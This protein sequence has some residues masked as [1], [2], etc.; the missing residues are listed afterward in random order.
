MS[1]TRQRPKIRYQD[2]G[3]P[4]PIIRIEI[5]VIPHLAQ[6]YETCGDWFR[7][8][9]K[10]GNA[11]LHIYASKLA[12]DTDPFNYM[13]LCVGSHELHEAL[14]CI[15]NGIYEVEVD[16]WDMDHKD[17]DDPGDNDLCPY[18]HQHRW[19]SRIEQQLVVAMNIMWSTY[20]KAIA[21]LWN[22][23]K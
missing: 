8:I 3:G 17:D 11:T 19:A 20:E 14:A 7:T 9:D 21:R 10:N 6:R 2:L 22:G 4:A 12:K 1:T 16:K 23:R 15:A 18:V 13:A 5:E